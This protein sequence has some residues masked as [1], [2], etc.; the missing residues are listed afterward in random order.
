MI[1]YNYVLTYNYV[2]FDRIS[3][4]LYKNSQNKKTLKAT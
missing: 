1:S 3:L 2:K 4:N